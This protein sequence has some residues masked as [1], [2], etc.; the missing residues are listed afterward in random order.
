MHM[1]DLI[2]DHAVLADCSKAEAARRLT[3]LLAQIAAALAAGQAVT[4]KGIGTLAPVEKAPRSGIGP[5][6][7][8]YAVPARLS[9]RLRP[10]GA[11]LEAL[12]AT[13]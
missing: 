9:V 4:L 12:N 6:G 5:D 10:A 1:I 3:L 8:P 7:T 13:A 11:L 2:T